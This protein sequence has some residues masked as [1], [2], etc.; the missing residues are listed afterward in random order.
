MA[1]Q[2]LHLSW[3]NPVRVHFGAGVW[4][5]IPAAPA[6]VVL[7]DRAALSTAQE[8]ALRMRLGTGCLA[9]QWMQPGLA[10]LD[11]ARSHCAAL[12]P[13][14]R[15]A[16]DA[17]VLAIGGGSTLDL[18]KVVRYCFVQDSHSD[19]TALAWRNNTLPDD[20]QRHTLW[21][22]PTTAGTGSEV[23]RSAT[24]WDTD[25]PPGHKLAWTPPDGFADAAWID[26]LLTLSCPASVTRDC[27]L[28]TLAHALEVLWNRRCNAL[29]ASLAVTAARD[30]LAYLPQVLQDPQD[31]EART[32]LCRASWLAGTAMSHT[33]TALAHAL[34]YAV[35]LQEG[36]QHGQACALWLPM[37]WSL[38]LGQDTQCDH[39]LGQV[40]NTPP[41]D[42]VRLLGDWLHALGIT[43][44]ELRDT[45]EGRQQLAEALQS[46]RGRNFIGNH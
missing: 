35:T 34:S 6:V 27:A 37:A 36:M 26:P 5:S 13:A 11:Q 28:D 20:A 4:E 43:T 10:S 24:V 44:R 42:G 16:P 15:L 19:T 18:A 46:A 23:S 22:V 12:W 38:A 40:F 39:H 41:E 8:V 30:V 14:M 29:T 25:T 9:W 1:A 31:L 21:A 17:V 2:A 45:A 7:A 3:H 32:A 33:Q